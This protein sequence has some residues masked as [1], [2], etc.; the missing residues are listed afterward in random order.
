[1]QKVAEVQDTESGPLVPG[2]GCAVH[3][4]PPHRHA[5]GPGPAALKP[6]ASQKL[7]DTHDTPLM[8]ARTPFDDWAGTGVGWI[9]HDVPFQPSARLI[10]LAELSVAVPTASQKAAETQETPLRALEVAPGGVAAA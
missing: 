4:V 6:T 1:M 2:T 7:S 8:V 9:C 3:E 5:A 10:T